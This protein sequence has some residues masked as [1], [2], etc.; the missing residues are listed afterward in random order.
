MLVE[1]NDTEIKLITILK[2]LNNSPEPIGSTKIYRMLE[3]DGI[4]SNERTIRYYLKLADER[5]YTLPYGQDGRMITAEGRRQIRDA[6]VVS[7]LDTSKYKLEKLA[8]QTTFDPQKASGQLP[9]NVSLIRD[10]N[11]KE[12]LRYMNDACKAGFC[13]SDLMAVA[14]EGEIIGSVVI[15]PGCVGLATVC[16][17]TINGVLLK[18][19]VPT[20]YSFGGLLEICNFQP[21]RF[22]AI[23]NYD[24]SSLDPSEEFIRSRMT[25]VGETVKTGAGKI[26]GVFRT[27]PALAK[28]IVETK[29]S[30]LNEAGIGGVSAM[31][32]NG[33]PVYRIS[34]AFDRVGLVQ[35]SGLNSVAAAVE[36]GIEIETIAGSGMIEFR[37]LRHVAELS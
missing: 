16:S 3:R 21:K 23:I 30:L 33:E 24:G 11:I 32:R 36:A 35:L 29:I 7:K 17:V 20:E 22:V 19:G 14:H 27:M 2:L 31:G 5:G 1:E 28:E 15:P 34:V 8:Y 37:H 12:A 10:K 4:V 9:V 18:A 25:S 26:I 6:L 13:V